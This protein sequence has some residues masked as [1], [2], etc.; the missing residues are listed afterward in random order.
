M[1]LALTRGT[2]VA[3]ANVRDT[4]HCIERHTTERRSAAI[5]FTGSPD[6]SRKLKRLIIYLNVRD[7]IY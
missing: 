5:V 3:R 2:G 7:R 4:D 6:L 1:S